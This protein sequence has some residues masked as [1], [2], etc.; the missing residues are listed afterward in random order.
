M[1]DIT[2]SKEWPDIYVIDGM[3]F[4]G[5]LL[6]LWGQSDV[7]SDWFRIIKREDGVCTIES[8]RDNA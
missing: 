8:K 4:T 2:I 5:A 6:R 1:K 7:P 3:K